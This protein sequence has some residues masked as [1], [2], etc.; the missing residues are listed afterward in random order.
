M[1]QLQTSPI[2]SL[3]RHGDQNTVAQ[4]WEKGK[5]HAVMSSFATVIEND[6]RK[7]ALLLYLLDTET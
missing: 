4:Q 5:N 7:K 1:S 3:Q 6:E 2:P